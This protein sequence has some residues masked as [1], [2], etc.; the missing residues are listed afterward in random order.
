MNFKAMSERAILQTLGERLKQERLNQN[1]RQADLAE[2]A[3]VSVIVVQRVEGGFGCTLNNFV[4]ILRSL[5]KLDSLDAFLPEPGPS[6]IALADME[7]RR[8]KEATGARGRPRK[9][10]P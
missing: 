4:R 9:E 6:P 5:D 10:S 2:Q 8:R 1:L 3:G 7:G